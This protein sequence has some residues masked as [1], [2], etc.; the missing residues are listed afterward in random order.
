[1]MALINIGMPL[2][3][4]DRHG[5]DVHIG[6]TLRF[7]ETEWGGPHTFTVEM[8]DGEINVSGTVQDISEWCE[9]LTKFD[10]T[11]VRQ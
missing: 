3:L 10:G 7:D 6:D 1:M 5:D 4:K 8:E 2:G 11:K 9:I